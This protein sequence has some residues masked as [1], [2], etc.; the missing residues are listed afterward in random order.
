MKIMSGDRWSSGD[1][2]SDPWLSAT[3]DAHCVHSSDTEMRFNDNFVPQLSPIDDQM[4]RKPLPDSQ[5]YI[6][7]LVA[8]R[9]WT[10]EMLEKK[11]AKLKGQTS[12]EMSSKEMMSS[13]SAKRDAILEQLLHSTSDCRM[14]GDDDSSGGGGGVGG[15]Q[16]SIVQYVERRLFPQMQALTDEELQRLLQCD[17][18]EKVVNTRDTDP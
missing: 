13:L 12:A 1:R 16:S 18:L 15:N 11:L 7:S 8:I 10:Y 17:V 4:P 5:Q 9:V 6:Q 14:S 3:G 2:P